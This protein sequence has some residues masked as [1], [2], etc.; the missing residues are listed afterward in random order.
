M[1]LIDPYTPNLPGAGRW[2]QFCQGGLV[3]P[4]RFLHCETA[5]ILCRDGWVDIH[6]LSGSLV[7]GRHPICKELVYD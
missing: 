3:R 5:T 7:D 2:V 4:G 1:L 6:G